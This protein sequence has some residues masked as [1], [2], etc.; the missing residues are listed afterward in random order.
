MKNP[1]VFICHSSEDKDSIVRSLAEGLKERGYAVWYDEFVLEAGDSLRR[2][3]DRGLSQAR[4]GIVILSRSF[5]GRNWPQY[6]LDGLVQRENAAGTKV[7]LPIWHGIDVDEVRQFSPS[8]ADRVAILSRTGIASV[9]EKISGIVGSPNS[10]PVSSLGNAS[11]NHA[12]HVDLNLTSI[13]KALGKA[14][15]SHE[16]KSILHRCEARPDIVAAGGHRIYNF[17]NDGVSFRF[18]R[19]PELLLSVSLHS[20]WTGPFAQYQGRLPKRLSFEDRMGDVEAR[21]GR[22]KPLQVDDAAIDRRVRRHRY[23]CPISHRTSPTSREPHRV[24]HPWSAVLRCRANRL[25][26]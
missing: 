16:V 6:E 13:G 10:P 7:I 21:L 20:G 8:L 9:V 17:F 19:K 23:Y 3:I 1:D 14:S 24:N 18:R 5:F 26:R 15:D 12:H 2:S 4:Y 11:G 25:L 22:G